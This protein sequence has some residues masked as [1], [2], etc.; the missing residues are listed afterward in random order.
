MATFCSF[1]F[2]FPMLCFLGCLLLFFYGY[3]ECMALGVP[4]G[5]YDR[6]GFLNAIETCVPNSE[7]ESRFG[8]SND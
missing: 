4:P 8:G 7:E 5:D 2:L 6:E 3:F 1:L